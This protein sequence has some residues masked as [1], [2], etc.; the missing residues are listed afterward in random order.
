MYAFVQSKEENY[1]RTEKEL[2]NSIEKIHELYLYLM[3][4]FTELK[5]VAERR[6]EENKTKRRPSEEDLNPNT[7]FVN[8]TVL[9][10]ID[11]SSSLERASKDATVSWVGDDNRE[12]F[13]KMYVQIKESESYF[14]YMNEEETSVELE[15]AFLIELF[16]EEIANSPMIYHFFEEKSIHW[17]DDIDLACS[18]VIKTIKGFNEDFNDI[19]PLYKDKDD[20]LDFVKS[21]FRETIAMEEESNELIQSLTQNWELDRIAKMD[22]ILMKMAITEMQVFSSVPTKVTLN[23]YIEISKFY[24]TPKSNLFI[25]GILDK[26]IV[27]LN[28]KDKINKIGRGLIN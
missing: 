23:E 18:M 26:A 17:L 6:I 8:N 10:W 24:S 25:N 28:E 15:K 4:T 21:L 1:K 13:K 20:E 9:S 11:S 2:L 12:M 14:G 7:K 16:K 19:M 3:L 22:V 27:K 5:S